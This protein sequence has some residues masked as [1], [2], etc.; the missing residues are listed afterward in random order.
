LLSFPLGNYTCE[1]EWSGEPKQIVHYLEVQVPP[2]IEAVLPGRGGLGLGLNTAGGNGGGLGQQMVLRPLEAREG[3]SISLEC[4][5]DG[6]PPPIIRW[7]RPVS[8]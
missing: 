5:A 4:R 8:L 6:I 7:R 2:Q 3:S 1:V